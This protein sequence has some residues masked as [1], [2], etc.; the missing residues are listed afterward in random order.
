MFDDAV[1]G[2]MEA[3]L[4]LAIEG[5]L[6][7]QHLLVV[8]HGL[9]GVPESLTKSFPVLGSFLADHHGPGEDPC[10]RGVLG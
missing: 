8:A 10:F 2:A 1:H 5:Q 6:I 7:D 3:G 4:L 9:E